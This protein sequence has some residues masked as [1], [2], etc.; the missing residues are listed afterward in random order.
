MTSETDDKSVPNQE[1]QQKTQQEELDL[2]DPT[3]FELMLDDN[4]DDDTRLQNAQKRLIS[5]DI[6][7]QKGVRMHGNYIVLP[8]RIS[9]MLLTLTM[10][11]FSVIALSGGFW[12]FSSVATNYLFPFAVLQVIM[13][14]QIGLYHSSYRAQRTAMCALVTFTT[15]G[16]MSY[17][18]WAFMDL[19]VYP[20]RADTPKFML[21][22]AMIGFTCIPMSMFAHLVFLGRGTRTVAVRKIK[23]QKRIETKIMESPAVVRRDAPESELPTLITEGVNVQ[24]KAGK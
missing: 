8:G 24:R 14:V 15:I 6:S 17:I 20:K 2:S 9:L 22:T 3:G 13:F 10:M 12:Y 23:D 21:W 16:I 19:I 5:I 18:D 11:L 7:N 4:P 1:L